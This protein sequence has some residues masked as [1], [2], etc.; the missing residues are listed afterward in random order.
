MSSELQLHYGLAQ[1][2]VKAILVDVEKLLMKMDIIY[3]RV[4]LMK[5]DTPDILP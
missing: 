2:S 5:E 3:Y 1:K 4:A